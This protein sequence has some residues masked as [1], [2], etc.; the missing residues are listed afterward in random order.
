MG[1]IC[2]FWRK[3]YRGKWSRKISMPKASYRPT[4]LLQRLEDFSKNYQFSNKNDLDCVWKD[5]KKVFA[6]MINESSSKKSHPH[7]I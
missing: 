7:S 1:E 3:N 5:F 6:D 2:L 4:D